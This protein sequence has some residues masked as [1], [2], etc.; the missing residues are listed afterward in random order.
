[1][2]CYNSFVLKTKIFKDVFSEGSTEIN[3]CVL[4][5]SSGQKIE[6]GDLNSLS[7]CRFDK[8]LWRPLCNSSD[9]D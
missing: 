3:G 4:T 6:D 9:A 8:S 2:S 1:M 5:G 7:V